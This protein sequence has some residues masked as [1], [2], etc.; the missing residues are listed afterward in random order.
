MG[1][2]VKVLN[3]QVFESGKLHLWLNSTRSRIR[4]IQRSATI[5]MRPTTS[6]AISYISSLS[7]KLLDSSPN[8]TA[9]G[10][11]EMDGYK[12]IYFTFVTWG[13]GPAITAHGLLKA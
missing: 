10:S 13:S 8:L 6:V 7:L 2:K 3:T 11:W 4:K 12:S 9:H 5:V 1:V